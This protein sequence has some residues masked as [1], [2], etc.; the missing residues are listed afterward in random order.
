MRFA[1]LGS[2]S[3]GNALV[4]EAA[5]G[6]RV[7]LDCGFGPRELGRRLARLG[8]AAGDIDAIA[9]THEHSDHSA[10]VHAFA[11]RQEIELFLTQGSLAALSASG[12]DLAQLPTLRLIASDR[13]FSVGELQISAFPVPH[14]AR[15]PVQ[16]V[17]SDGHH[18][19]GVLTDAGVATAHMV[20][21]LDGC[22]ALVLECNHDEDML[23]RG[24]YPWHLQQRIGGAYGHLA[25]RQ[26][27]ALLSAL[28][29][30]RLRHLVAAHLSQQNNTVE[31]A[32]SALAA[33]A[34]SEEWITVASQE[35]GTPWLEL[36]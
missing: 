21:M 17:F 22:D 10:G 16:F 13:V 32:R 26:A 35:D 30:S 31:L 20:A 23:A 24:P 14:D 2:G 25:N 33:A 15:E 19:L 34:D 5:A 11:R 6:S 9:L 36:A 18:R 12:S 1:S 7:L 4:V 3:R 29:R 28:D 27:A 8:L